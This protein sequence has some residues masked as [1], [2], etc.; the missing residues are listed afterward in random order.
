MGCIEE[1]SRCLQCSFTREHCICA[2]LETLRTAESSCTTFTPFRR[3][4]FL[5]WMHY[6]ERYRASNT[7]KLLCKLFAGSRIFV[8][9][10]EED[11]VD[12]ERWMEEN[13]KSDTTL[14]VLL[15]PSVDA[16]DG[17]K[18]AKEGVPM[19]DVVGTKG[20]GLRTHSATPET[21][22]SSSDSEEGGGTDNSSS[23]APRRALSSFENLDVVLLDGT[24]SQARKMRKRVEESGVVANMIPVKISPKELSRFSCRRQT[25][26]DHISTLEAAAVLLQEL[27]GSADA[28]RSVE[29][30]YAA[31]QL[32]CSAMDRQSHKDT[33]P[34]VAPTK[35]RSARL[36]KNP[37]GVV[38]YG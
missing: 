25:Q 1:S 33:M 13:S 23:N 9:G 20:G 32:L 14:T 2:G 15:Y 29:R 19:L 24:W 35:N 12:F 3:V 5:P 6:K 10:L 30:M 4:R 11:H 8:D 22:D 17:T 37:H 31:L 18:L 7:G 28:G 36:P 26:D 21:A 38:V 16:V 27:G 34:Y